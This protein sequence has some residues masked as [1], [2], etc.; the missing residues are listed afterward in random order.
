MK[1]GSH[2]HEEEESDDWSGNEPFLNSSNF[3]QRKKL[4]NSLGK[5]TSYSS[6]DHSQRLINNNNKRYS[7]RET[8]REPIV[9]QAKLS[10]SKKNIKIAIVKNSFFLKEKQVQKG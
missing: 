9:I 10:N 4:N 7:A 2:R 1:R 3:T 8:Y 5:A 6:L